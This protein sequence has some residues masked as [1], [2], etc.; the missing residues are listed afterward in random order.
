MTTEDIERRVRQIQCAS[1]DSEVAHSL[2]DS[3]RDDFIKWIAS[4]ESLPFL[5]SK[6]KLVLSTNSIKF[7][8]W[9]A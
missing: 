4:I 6:A 1:G 9:R 2:E 7:E 3:L 5:S 8:R